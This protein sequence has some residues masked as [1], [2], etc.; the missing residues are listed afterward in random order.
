LRFEF[1]SS[2]CTTTGNTIVFN[3]S[4]LAPGASVTQTVFARVNCTIPD[5]I[6]ITNSATVTSLT[7]DSNLANNAAS[8]SNPSSNPGIS[9]SPNV[10]FIS[11]AGGNGSVNVFSSTGCAWVSVSNVPWITITFSSN[12]CNGVVQFTVAANSGAPRTG[13]ITIANRIFTVNQGGI[14]GN[15]TIGL[16]RQSGNLFFLRN[17]NSPGF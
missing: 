12:C 6:T 7:P 10:Q 1:C 9:I 4:V 11:N 8:A 5:G 17:S 2:G 16:F 3:I 13:T 15:D 14:G